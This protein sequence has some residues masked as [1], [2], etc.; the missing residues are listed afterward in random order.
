LRRGDAETPRRGDAEL[1]E[2]ANPRPGNVVAWAQDDLGRDRSVM[3]APVAASPR[4]RVPASAARLLRCPWTVTFFALAFFTLALGPRWVARDTYVTADE[5]NWM[6]RAG[7]FAW[8][9]AHGRLGR[10][11]QNGHP[12][13]LTMELAILGQGPGG[14]ERFG[15]PVTGNPTLV[16]SVPGFFEGLVDA[17]RAFALA[18]AGLVVG[19][20]LVFWRLFGL[21]AAVFGGLLLALDPFYLGHSQLVHLDAVLA[22]CMGLAVLCGLVRWGD[23]AGSR[24]WVVGC[25]MFS[26]LALL[27]KAPAIYLFVLIPLLATWLAA[28]KI[29]RVDAVRSRQS[30]AEPD[31]P[32]KQRSG[33]VG[34]RLVVGDLALWLASSLATFVA[35][36]PSLWVNP[37]STVTR[38]LE[39]ARETGGQPHE[40][41]SFFLSQP[42]VDP[43]PLFYLVAVPLRL[44]PVTTLGLLAL[45][46]VAWRM[47]TALEPE[48]ARLILVLLGY[49]V[50][51]GVFMTMAPKKFD[52][53]LL[54]A[55]PVLDLLAG[56]GLWL[57]ARGLLKRLSISPSLVL[58][59]LIF[60]L[61]AWP[62]L[63]VFP[64]YLAYYNP[65][66]GGGQAAVRAI[67]VGQGEG[68][69]EAARWL[70]ARPGAENLHVAS[71]SFDVL[72]STFVGGGE[73]LRDRVSASTDYVVL[74]VYQTQ[75]A[76]SP[77]VALEYSGHEPEYTVR[78]NGIEYARVY[79]G[80][81][82]P[83]EAERADRPA[84]DA[85]G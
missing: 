24:G 25:G 17:R 81:R 66:L 47:R 82:R 2:G 77:R 31:N 85:N 70:N 52:R 65:L 71:D 55:F 56:L 38:M 64:H 84:G 13:V 44:S 27:A 39:F 75:I 35:L 28:V 37:L 50:G 49:V 48:R 45:G 32:R 76:H 36:W 22:G 20:G 67:P 68:L 79:R 40:Q 9:I 8:G 46:L 58:A 5:D 43:G 59:I 33:G 15:D 74:Y 29:S 3:P 41:G 54:P 60:A 10:T 1:K 11:Y 7:G 14:A 72:K 16:A 23:L 78:L 57:A 4:P 73:T 62:L 30:G 21:G 80:P 53:Y 83:A 26:G 69:V 18:T 42:V 63:S 12:G 19:L 61:A 34:W 6:R 51:F